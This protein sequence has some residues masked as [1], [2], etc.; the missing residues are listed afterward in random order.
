MRDNIKNYENLL[1]DLDVE[2]QKMK[3]RAILVSE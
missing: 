1:G 2:K 3:E